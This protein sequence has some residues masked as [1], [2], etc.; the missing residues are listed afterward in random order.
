M[1]AAPIA[2]GRGLV[3]QFTVG[4]AN[5]PESA[6]SSFGFVDEADK[7]HPRCV[8][9]TRGKISVAIGVYRSVSE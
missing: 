4:Q 5:A 9:K 8:A 7:A 2:E 1:A 3:A 6:Q